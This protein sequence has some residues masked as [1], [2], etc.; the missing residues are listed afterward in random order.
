MWI[1]LISLF[2]NNIF[3]I[4]ILRILCLVLANILLLVTIIDILLIIIVSR[5]VFATVLLLL[6]LLNIMSV[7]LLVLRRFL[8]RRRYIFFIILFLPLL[9]L[10]II[11]LF[12]VVFL[13]RTRTLLSCFFLWC[14]SFFVC[15]SGRGQTFNPDRSAWPIKRS[16]SL[17]YSG[18][19]F[20]GHC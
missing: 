12:T 2:I 15:G 8:L 14:F 1:P 13:G 10:H 18:V 9:I 17:S 19:F 20:C 4:T 7:I 3:D 16:A 5:L 6:L 11:L